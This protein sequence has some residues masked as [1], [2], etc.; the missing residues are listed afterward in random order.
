MQSVCPWR[1]KDQDSIERTSV[2]CKRVDSVV[3]S[4][5]VVSYGV[6][7]A[8][9][10]LKAVKKSGGEQKLFLAV[11]HVSTGAESRVLKD[12]HSNY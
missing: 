8:V 2:A 9:Y 3:N 12:T 5:I 1:D 7:N 10:A 6:L 11:A 4:D